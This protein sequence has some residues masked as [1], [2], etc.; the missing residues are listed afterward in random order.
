MKEKCHH[1]VLGRFIKQCLKAA[2]LNIDVMC[3]EIHMGPATY[4]EIKR[5]TISA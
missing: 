2:G 4:E 5:A 1:Y 3:A